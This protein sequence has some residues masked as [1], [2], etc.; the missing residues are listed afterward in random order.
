MRSGAIS[1]LPPLSPVEGH[2]DP[3]RGQARRDAGLQTFRVLTLWGIP[4]RGRAAGAPPLP[5]RDR[6][7]GFCL[8]GLGCRARPARRRA[9]A[10]RL[11]AALMRVAPLAGE[12][13]DSKLGP[14]EAQQGGESAMPPGQVAIDVAVTKSDGS[15]DP[16]NG[17]AEFFRRRS[18]SQDG[19]ATVAGGP[20]VVNSDGAVGFAGARG[21]MSLSDDRAGGIIAQRRA[22]VAQHDRRASQHGTFFH[23]GVDTRYRGTTPCPC[24]RAPNHALLAYTS[25][26]GS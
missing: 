4:G 26:R 13:T 10:P 3:R 24:T 25:L 8:A 22:S 1:R 21:R 20:R 16:Q 14:D 17:G 2:Q 11:C 19:S 7:R 15:G 12:G 18:L 23:G 6:S 9:P 5:V